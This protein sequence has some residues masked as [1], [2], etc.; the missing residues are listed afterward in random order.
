MANAK[1]IKRKIG[2]IKNTQK[3]TKAMELI[4]T[5]K[6]KK[7][8]DLALSKREFILEMLKIF[9]RVEEYLD[10]FPL[11][12]DG[13]GKKTLAVV[14]TSNK[15]LCWGYNVNVMK[16]VNSYI[17]ETNEKLDFVTI[18]KKAANFVARTG[19]NLIADF[20]SDFTD[21]IEPLFTKDISQLLREEFLSGKYAKVVVFYNYYVNTIKQVAIAKVSLPIGSDEIKSYLTKV[22]EGYFSGSKNSLEE[23]LNS[24]VSSY[25][26]EPTAQLLAME[27]VPM[28]L[29]MIFHGILLEAKA[30]EHSSRM[31]AMKAA[32]DN[33]G[34]IASDLTLR[35]NKARQAMITREVSEITAWVESMKDA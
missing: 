21:S 20:S 1:E 9:L 29:D 32:K 13:Q 15:W 7:A 3:I 14:I 8:S 19:N 16:K 17:K 27:V 25:E 4:S 18:W 6:M 30:S 11:F 12:Y 5:V 26:L 10:D 23:E 28:I 22:L 33:A 35:Y 31:V 34:K 2:S 24:N